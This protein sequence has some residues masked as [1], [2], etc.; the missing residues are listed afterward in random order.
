MIKLISL[1]LF[2]FSFNAYSSNAIH[3]GTHYGVINTLGLKDFKIKP[4]GLGYHAI[5]SQ[6]YGRFGIE[7]SFRQGAYKSQVKYDQVVDNLTH[8]QRTL[9]LGFYFGLSRSL[10]F[11]AGLSWTKIEHKLDGAISELTKV[12][13][14]NAWKL[15]DGRNKSSYYWGL[16]YKI[17]GARNFDIY[18]SYNHQK[19]LESGTEHALGL[20]V[21]VK[22]DLS[23]Y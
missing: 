13:M 23:S 12:A 3:L 6:N 17:F 11:R 1:A 19:I 21:T 14:N 4:K 7:G 20:G 5:F 10:L 18:T 15:S 8:E 16:Q 2:L 22:F 9:G